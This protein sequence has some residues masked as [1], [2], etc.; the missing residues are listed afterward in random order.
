MKE[1]YK[2]I[3]LFL[4]FWIASLYISKLDKKNEISYEYYK[5][6]LNKQELKIIDFAFST[7]F[8]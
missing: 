5:K 4:L 2:L 3:F 8:I 7:K 6:S 1:I